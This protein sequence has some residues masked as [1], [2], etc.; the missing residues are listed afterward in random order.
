MLEK[1][2][3]FFI[4]WL[5]VRKRNEISFP[6]PEDRLTFLTEDAMEI[7]FEAYKAG[8]LKGRDEISPNA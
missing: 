5:K 4:D 7:I 8:F 3:E 2:E 1:M 6:I